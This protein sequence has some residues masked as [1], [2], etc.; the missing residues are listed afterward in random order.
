M[1][2]NRLKHF[3]GRY[4]PMHLRGY[5]RSHNG[6]LPPQF[7]ANHPQIA[8]KMTER[9][10]TRFPNGVPETVAGQQ[11]QR[12]NGQPFTNGVF[13]HPQ[14]SDFVHPVFGPNQPQSGIAPGEPNPATPQ[15]PQYMPGRTGLGIGQIPDHQNLTPEEIE[16]YRSQFREYKLSQM[17]VNPNRPM[18][19]NGASL[20]PWSQIG[21]EE[22]QNG[23]NKNNK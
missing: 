9:F 15:Q 3:L 7:A 22:V 17:Q 1:L 6:Q 5:M 18:G 16:Q 23:R 13:T 8:E 10:N 14:Q 2:K 20:N 11:Q 21:E 19:Y 12:P 4:R